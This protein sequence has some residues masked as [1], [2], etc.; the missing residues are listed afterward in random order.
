MCLFCIGQNFYHILTKNCAVVQIFI[1]VN[2]QI[3]ENL[4]T[5]LVTLPPNHHQYYG[6][7]HCP[8]SYVL[9]LVFVLFVVVLFAEIYLDDPLQKRKRKRYENLI[10]EIWG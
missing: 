2:D 1:T 6:S 7:K 4:S 8:L 3:L 9:T 5:Q 10:S